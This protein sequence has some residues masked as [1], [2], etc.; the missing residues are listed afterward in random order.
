L[1]YFIEELQLLAQNGIEIDKKVFGVHDVYFT[2]THLQLYILKIK[3]H[4]GFHFCL[5]CEQE[6]VYLLNRVCFSYLKP[7]SLASKR[8]H[9]NYLTKSSEDY[10]TGDLSIVAS[11]NIDVVNDFSLDY[12]H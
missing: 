10:Y 6:G 11:V 5:R 8:K 4:S 7:E 3:G 12:L 9:S 2:V 1:S